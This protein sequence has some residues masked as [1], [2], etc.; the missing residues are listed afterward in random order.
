MGSVRNGLGAGWGWWVG[1]RSLVEEMLEETKRIKS[2]QY[3]Q[4]AGR[5]LR[6]LML[7]IWI[8]KRILL[9]TVAESH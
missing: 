5:A 8:S 4:R 2:R 1:K 9:T 3:V 7:V 6:S